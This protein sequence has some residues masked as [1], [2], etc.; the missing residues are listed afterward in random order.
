MRFDWT[1]NV[2]ELIAATVFFGGLVV[3]HIQNVRRLQDIA[4]KVEMIYDW[5]QATIVNRRTR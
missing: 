2:G 3:A 1:I 5:F 4:T